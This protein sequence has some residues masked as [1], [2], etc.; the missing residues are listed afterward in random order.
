[1]C[2]GDVR[3][4]EEARLRNGFGP[5]SDCLSK[6]PMTN[7]FQKGEFTVRFEPPDL[8]FVAYSGD[9]DGYHILACEAE[10][11]S[12]LQSIPVHLAIIDVSRIN[13]F[14]ARAREESSRSAARSKSLL[15]GS[16]IIGASFHHR[17]MG[18]LITKAANL[19]YR[20]YEN[21]IVFVRDEA[22]A[23]EWAIARRKAINNS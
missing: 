6:V 12:F 19:L 20:R 5:F 4:T 10:C 9:I 2:R 1:V 13:S 15:S 16:A 18:S 11:N 23:R 22:E 3:V 21:P 14:S 8:L 7:S 17:V